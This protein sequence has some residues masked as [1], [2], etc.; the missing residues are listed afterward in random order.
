MY[1]S[2]CSFSLFSGLTISYDFLFVKWPFYPLQNNSPLEGGKP[3]AQRG[4]H[5]SWSMIARSVNTE[6]ISFQLIVVSRTTFS[7]PPFRLLKSHCTWCSFTIHLST[8]R[9][10][11]LFCTS[12]AGTAGRFLFSF[13]LMKILSSGRKLY[14]IVLLIGRTLPEIWIIRTRSILYSIL[15]SRQKKIRD[16]PL[17]QWRIALSHS[18]CVS[19]CMS[20]HQ[21]SYASCGS[22]SQL[23]NCQRMSI[24]MVCARKWA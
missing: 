1:F 15:S 5:L 8:F 18:S 20:T 14:K 19:M 7:R 17:P 9:L 23:S 11:C 16:P 21:R 22:K 13:P 24:A 2:F 12:Y 6:V 3:V 10:W 4:A